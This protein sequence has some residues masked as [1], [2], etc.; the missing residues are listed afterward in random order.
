MQID[1]DT[2]IGPDGRRHPKTAMPDPVGVGGMKS[3]GF[4]QITDLEAARGLGTIPENVSYAVVQA[5]G[6]DIRYRDDG[7]DPTAT[8]GFLLPAGGSMTYVGNL[9]DLQMIEA[10]AGGIVNVAFYQVSE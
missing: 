7:D 10:A 8:V 1:Q 5:E 2:Q 4:T 3:R 6:A 9:D